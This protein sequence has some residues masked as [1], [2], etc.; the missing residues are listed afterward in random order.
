MRSQDERDADTLAIF[1]GLLVFAAILAGGVG[2]AVLVHRLAGA[3]V[4]APAG[5]VLLVAAALTA[6]V[7]IRRPSRHS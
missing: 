5:V 1:S 6:V 7:R 4:P 2:A 3:D